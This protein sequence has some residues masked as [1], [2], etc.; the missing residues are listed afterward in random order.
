M[1]PGETPSPDLR[2][3]RQE[4][5]TWV[6][7]HDTGFNAA[8]QD[9]FLHWL[10]ADARHREWFARQKGSWTALDGLADWRPVHSAEPN[11]DLLARRSSRRRR[12]Q[13]AMFAAAAC[14]AVYFTA[15]RGDAPPPARAAPLLE[16][17]VLADG[18]VAELSHG[19]NAE[20][21]FT[22]AQR[23]VNLLRGEARFDVQKDAA[24][25][26]VVRAG[27]LD[28]RAVGTSFNVRLSAR[29]VEVVV[30]SGQVEVAAA[31]AASAATPASVALPLLGAGQRARLSRA[32]PLAA[33]E[34]TAVDE[35]EVRRLQAWQPQLLDFSSAPLRRVVEEFNRL[36]RRQVV[37]L[38]SDLGDVP[39]VASFRSDNLDGFLELLERTAEISVE[40]RDDS[41]IALRRSRR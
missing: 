28:V 25:P 22:K 11:P 24:R 8:E 5:A 36:N 12:L 4:A 21:L 34:I 13:V 40:R 38:D 3:I 7:K 17:R 33:P 37:L 14:I 1:I 27:E 30:T 29:T 19:A 9:E 20:V 26:F 18:S 41:V 6:V 15:R 16:R 32:R 31:D 23:R 39:I 35:E 2:R 10:G